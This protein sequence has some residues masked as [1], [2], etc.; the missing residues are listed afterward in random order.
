MGLRA[1]LPNHIPACR[2]EFSLFFLGGGESSNSKT[3]SGVPSAALNLWGGG[4]SDSQNFR[5]CDY[6]CLSHANHP[7]VKFKRGC[8]FPYG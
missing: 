4:G 8:Q 3:L 7:L 2:S 1:T 6:F 5:E